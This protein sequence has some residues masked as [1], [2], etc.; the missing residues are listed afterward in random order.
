MGQHDKT[1]PGLDKSHPNNK[2]QPQATSSSESPPATQPPLP[3]SSI[4]PQPAPD[5]IQS[6]PS[7]NP[8]PSQTLSSAQSPPLSP[9]V[10]SSPDAPSSTTTPTDNTSSTVMKSNSTALTRT[11][12]VPS[13]SPTSLKTGFY[14]SG[15]PFAANSPT[16]NDL[17]PDPGQTTAVPP[18]QDPGTSLAPTLSATGSDHSMAVKV[19]LPVVAVFLLILLAVFWIM[20]IRRQRRHAGFN[21]QIHS[22]PGDDMDFIDVFAPASFKLSSS[23]PMNGYRDSGTSTEALVATPSKDIAH[24]QHNISPPASVPARGINF[25]NDNQTS[26]Y[27]GHPIPIVTPVENWRYTFQDYMNDMLKPEHVPDV[28]SRTKE[29]KT[30]FKSQSSYGHAEFGY[31]M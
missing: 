19:A 27:P 15:N 13:D 23:N 8:L 18:G 20:R 11:P 31:A 1:P 7:N 25:Q 22:Q 14:S 9:V 6:S 24:L 4:P 12:A 5:P 21:Q 26:L 30:S 2:N 28:E 16:P 17:I 10:P 3:A 29:R